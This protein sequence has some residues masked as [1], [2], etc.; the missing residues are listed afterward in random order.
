[1]KRTEVLQEIRRMR[2]QK[3]YAV[4]GVVRSR[5]RGPHRRRREPPPRAGMPLHQDE[6]THKWV[7]Q[8]YWDSRPK[9]HA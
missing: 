1:M 7:A 3:A 5:A 2:F 6:S 4:R 8:R 9:C